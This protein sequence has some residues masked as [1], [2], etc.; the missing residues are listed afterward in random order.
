M[1]KAASRLA[2]IALSSADA[3][4]TAAVSDNRPNT[5]SRRRSRA[6]RSNDD[7]GDSEASAA[8][9]IHSFVP[10]TVPLIPSYEGS[11]TPM[12][13][14]GWSDIRMVWPTIAGFAANRIRHTAWLSTATRAP[15]ASS[16]AWITR[17]SEAPMRSVAKYAPSTASVASSSVVD[18]VVTPRRDDA[19]AEMRAKEVC[20][21][22]RS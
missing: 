20:A 22:R 18:E 21:A 16:A 13:S 4:A 1:G 12:T 11:A 3:V 10:G 17:P 19:D 6:G 9:G 8:S 5:T 2:P 14:K 15:A 7:D